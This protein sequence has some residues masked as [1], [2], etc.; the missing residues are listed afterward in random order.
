VSAAESATWVAC[1]TPPGVG[2]IATLAVRGPRAWD[3][4]RELFQPLSATSRPLPEQ[5]QEGRF[6]LGKLG[7]EL[8]DEV[9]LAVKRAGPSPWLEIHCHGGVEVVR[10]LTETIA[11][12][13]AM[14]CTWAEL[15]QRTAGRSLAA[16]A[17]IPLSQALTVRTA[18]V[19]LDQMNGA[20]ERTVRSV[21]ERI[22]G[23]DRSEAMATLETLARSAAL[24]RHLVAPWQVAVLGPPNVGKSS[25]VN[26]LVGFQRSIVSPTPGTTRD[27]VTALIAVDGWP[28]ELSDT[29]GLREMGEELEEEGMRRARRAADAADLC[30][31]LL[32][33]SE[34]PIYPDPAPDNCLFVINK[35]DL[36]SAWHWRSVSDAVTVSAKTGAGIG[37]LCATI[38]RW[39]VPKPPPAGTPVVYTAE[40]AEAINAALRAC[41]ADDSAEAVHLLRRLLD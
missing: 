9:V 21:V 31:W 36:P 33:A 37:D 1:L 26:A 2:A 11:T 22:D 15:E 38:A 30:L 14:V 20:L 29:A 24:G 18:A 17:A 8:V 5:P 6:R 25:L 23:S 4:V 39:L 7:G 3:I 34:A 19:L 40:Q 13:G 16:S 27:V 28:V 35:T 10:L 41:R 12:K 32:D